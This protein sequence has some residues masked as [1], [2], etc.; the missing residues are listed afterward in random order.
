MAAQFLPVAAVMHLRPPVNLLGR[1]SCI[2]FDEMSLQD[3]EK[4]RD[5]GIALVQ[6]VVP[7][8]DAILGNG[9]R[10]HRAR[11]VHDAAGVFSRDDLCRR[12]AVGRPPHSRG[13][14]HSREPHRIGEIRASTA[15]QSDGSRRG[16][17]SW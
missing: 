13:P 10:L 5:S 9:A 3:A 4:F 12:R 11:E 6:V 8:L 17:S 7:G 16:G 1:E 14:L 15:W 2:E